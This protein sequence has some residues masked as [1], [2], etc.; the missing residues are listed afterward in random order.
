MSRLKAYEEKI[1]RRLDGRKNPPLMGKYS[2]AKRPW[3]LP[4]A[5]MW[6]VI[7]NLKADLR[8]RLPRHMHYRIDVEFMGSRKFVRVKVFAPPVNETVTVNGYTYPN[9]VSGDLVFSMDCAVE[10]FPSQELMGRIYLIC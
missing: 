1:K 3:V 7:D 2:S 8:L 9:Y 10:G 6:P 5:A 4:D